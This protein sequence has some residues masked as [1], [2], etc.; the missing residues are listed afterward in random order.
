MNK[1]R[2]KVLDANIFFNP[3]MSYR[4]FKR[5][6]ASSKIT[7]VM[8]F[9]FL[10]MQSYSQCSLKCNNQVNISLDENCMATITPNMII[11]ATSTTCPGAMLTVRLENSNGGIIS[12]PNV[13]LTHI[14]QT[15]SAIVTD[16]NSG[17]SC[18][19]N[20]TVEYKLA[21]KIQCPENDTVS[22]AALDVLG[23]PTATAQCGGGSFDVFLLDEQ[24]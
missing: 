22:C 9:A 3:K 13:G 14:D 6:T 1:N 5:L 23:V 8:L 20:V 19:G 7:F 18:W 15:F 21:P 2:F 12:P 10:S 17:N 4:H 11:N 16:S 24:S